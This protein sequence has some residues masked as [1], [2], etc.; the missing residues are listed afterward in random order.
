[1]LYE[2]W[3][4][5]KDFFATESFIPDS[6]IFNEPYEIEGLE[7]FISFRISLKIDSN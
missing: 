3:K 4:V 2:N 7:S 6:I 1:M 5:T